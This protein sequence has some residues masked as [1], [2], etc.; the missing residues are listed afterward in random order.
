SCRRAAF[1]IGS[2]S[3][4]TPSR[5]NTTAATGVEADTRRPYRR[6]CQHGAVLADDV[7]AI[8]SLIHRYAELLDGGDLDG[9]AH[10]FAHASWGSPGRGERL[11]GAADVR[12]GYDGVILYEDG[13]PSTKHVISN[14][15]IEVGDDRTTAR[16]RSYFTVL[17]A[18]PGF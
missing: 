5:S 17:Q 7:E 4:S 16:A 18:R 6:T 14:V 3:R 9:V 10:L 2:E 13:T 11:R 1:Q 12:R 8:G 15:S